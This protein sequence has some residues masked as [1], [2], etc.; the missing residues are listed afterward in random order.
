MIGTF[1]ADEAIDVLFI[2]GSDSPAGAWN[3]KINT[4]LP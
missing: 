4:T 2:S 3:S 1:D